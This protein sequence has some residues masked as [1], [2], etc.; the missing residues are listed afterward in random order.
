MNT[1]YSIGKIFAVVGLT[2]MVW[3][4]AHQSTRTEVLGT[5]TLKLV[6]GNG[7]ELDPTQA[8]DTQW[9]LANSE[10]N[11]Q[12]IEIKVR[13][14]AAPAGARWLNGGPTIDVP[15]P[16]P[17]SS[18][19]QEVDL[20]SVLEGNP[21]FSQRGVTVQSVEPQTARIRFVEV[22][23]VLDVRVQPVGTDGRSLAEVTTDPER[24]G[25]WLPT[26]LLESLGGPNALVVEAEI[27]AR[28]RQELARTGTSSARLRGL[29]NAGEQPPLPRFTR[30]DVEVQGNP[31]A[32]Q[33]HTIPTPVQLHV[34]G[35]P[36]AS[37]GFEL[38]PP[39]IS[40]VMVELN[41]EVRKELEALDNVVVLGIIH[42][43]R[44]ERVPGTDIQHRIDQFVIR[45]ADGSVESLR[46]KLQ[47]APS[48]L[49]RIRV[50][51]PE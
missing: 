12:I 51:E 46:W 4:L 16:E 48:E 39:A 36:E 30:Q 50:L 29:R 43:R 37:L 47:D 22:I 19:P 33:W 26:S 24:V 3:I 13:G 35:S 41:Q 42:L 38:T 18:E 7:Q 20:E 14:L 49:V 17:S 9:R 10:R 1:T 28:A 15:L 21:E 40:G 11:E 6:L 45:R 44:D 32:S 31:T 5:V 8:L 27:G 23:K 34:A 25:V 2:V